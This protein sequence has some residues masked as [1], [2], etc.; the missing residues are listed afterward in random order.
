MLNGL[1]KEKQNV[2]LS[3][4]SI[5]IQKH[6][7][8]FRRNYTS[9]ILLYFKLSSTLMNSYNF[10]EKNNVLRHILLQNNSNILFYMYTFLFKFLWI[11]CW[12]IVEERWRTLKF[13]I[14]S[15]FHFSR[16]MN[17]VCMCLNIPKKYATAFK[18]KHNV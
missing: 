12:D 14:T 7:H 6:F 5:L 9:K 17:Y 3:I 15:I 11:F 18:T 10:S 1:T 4:I 16:L 2:K 8:E 13:C